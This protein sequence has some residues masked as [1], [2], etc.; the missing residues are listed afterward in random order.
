MV[1]MLAKLERNLTNRL[2]H[3]YNGGKGDCPRTQTVGKISV[4]VLII[5]RQRR[6]INE[7]GRQLER[8]RVSASRSSYNVISRLSRVFGDFGFVRPMLEEILFPFNLRQE[9]SL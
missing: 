5:G 3:G 8:R 7:Q 2:Y 1:G 9:Y 4:Q 6:W